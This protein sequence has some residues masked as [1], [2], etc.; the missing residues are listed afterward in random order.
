LA[1]KYE[2]TTILK[3]NAILRILQTFKTNLL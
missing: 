1:A 3:N 2:V